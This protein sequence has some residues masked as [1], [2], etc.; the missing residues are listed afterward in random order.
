MMFNEYQPADRIFEDCPMCRHRGVIAGRIC[1]QCDGTGNHWRRVRLLNEPVQVG[2]DING[3]PVYVFKGERWQRDP[4]GSVR[5]FTS[6]WT[7]RYV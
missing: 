2:V 7:Q 3:E 5:R 4:N 6:E 1:Q